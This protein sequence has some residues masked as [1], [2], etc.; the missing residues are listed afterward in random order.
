MSD[1]NRRLWQLVAEFEAQLE[2]DTRAVVAAIQ[3]Q[4]KAEGYQGGGDSDALIKEYV[5]QFEA[6]LTVGIKSAT[7]LGIAGGGTSMRNKLVARLAKQAFSER[8]EDGKILSERIWWVRDGTLQGFEK[9]LADGVQ[10]GEAASGLI[11]DMQR[12]VERASGE[13]FALVISELDDWATELGHYS[14]T[15]VKTPSGRVK[16]DQLM[17]DAH[18][19][20]DGLA[21]N[22]TKHAAQTFIKK[23]GQF[24]KTGN[25]ALIDEAVQWWMY[26][27]QLYYLKRIARTELATAQHRAVIASTIEDEDV[28][29]YLWRLS[30]SH[31]VPDICDWYANI[32]MGLGRGV[33][34]KEAVPQHKAHPHCMCSISARVTKVKHAGSKTYGEFITGTSPKVRNALLPAWAKDALRQGVKIDKLVRPDGLDL[35]T[36][37]QAVTAGIIKATPA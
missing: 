27:K 12:A 28:I 33:W 24:V 16:L 23:L 21:D 14:K 30:P 15:L 7:A 35:L 32:D 22:G 6:A 20:I 18:L 29:G 2:G 5:S 10:A 34:T 9:I 3:A 26:D 13:K 17:R 1:P 36:K 31:P 25:E 37:E 19:R 4:L 11:Y 8:W